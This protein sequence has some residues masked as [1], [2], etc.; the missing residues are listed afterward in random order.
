MTRI[1][2]HTLLEKLGLTDLVID[3]P[4]DEKRVKKK[5]HELY[6]KLKKEEDE[7]EAKEKG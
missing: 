2:I 4:E 5:L 6:L 7:E 1:P 3:S